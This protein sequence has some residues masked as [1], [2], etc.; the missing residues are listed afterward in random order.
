MLQY[1]RS[2]VY[3]PLKRRKKLNL[4]GTGSRKCDCLFRLCGYFEKNTN[5]WWLVMLNEIHTMSS[6]QI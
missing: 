5:D 6:S 3:K 1:E 4:E 2:S